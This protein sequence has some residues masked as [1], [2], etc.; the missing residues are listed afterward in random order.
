M[1]TYECSLKAAQWYEKHD[2]IR[3]PGQLR[4]FKPIADI[5]KLNLPG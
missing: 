1:Y 2:F 3:F 4:M 5:R